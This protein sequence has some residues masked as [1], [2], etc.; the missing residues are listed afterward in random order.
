MHRDHE[1]DEPEGRALRIERR[2]LVHSLISVVTARVGWQ[3]L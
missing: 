3:L 1:G 2:A